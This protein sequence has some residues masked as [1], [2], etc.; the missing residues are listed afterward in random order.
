[1]KSTLKSIFILLTIINCSLINNVAA[2]ISINSDGAT[3]DASAM[4]DVSS[5]SKGILIPRMTTAERTTITS[6][7]TGLMVYDTDE[8]AFWYYN[9]TAWTAIG[10]SSAFTSENGITHSNSNSDDFVFGTGSLNHGSGTE[11]KMFFDKS[12]GAFRAGTV[13]GTNWDESNIGYYSTSM[14]YNTIASGSYATSFGFNTTASSNFS[15]SFGSSTTASGLFSTSFGSSTTASG[16]YATSFGESTTASGDFST[17]LGES[18]TASGHAATSLGSETL[19]SGDFSTSLGSVTIASGDNSTSLGLGT[20]AYSYGET[21]LG[22]YN[23]VYTPNDT[24]SFNSDDRLFVIGNGTAATKSDAMIVYKSGNTAINGDLTISGALVYD[25]AA[26]TSD[27]GITYSNNNDD[28]FLFGA[29]SLNYGSGTEYKM[30][31]D[32]SKG[33]FRAGTAIGT[34]WDESNVGIYSTSMGYN[35]IASGSYATS[36]GFNTTASGDFSTSFCSSTTASGNFSTSFGSSTTASGVFSTSFGESTTAS[37]AFSTSLG[38]ETTA[39]GHAATS[40]GSVTLASGNFSTSFGSATIASGD[41]ATSLGLGTTAYSY[42]ETALGLYNTVYTPNDTVSFNSDDRLFVIGNGTAATKSDAM[43]VYKSGN[44][45]INGDLTISGSLVYDAAAFTSDN[46]ITYSNNNNDDF[47]FGADSLNYGS[48]TEYKMFFDKS[49]GA[50]RAGTAIGTNWDE[51][52]IGSFSTSMGYNTTA[53]GSYATSFGFNTTA[54]GIFSTSFG[55]STTASGNFST[56]F[57]EATTAS[58]HYATSLGESTTASGHAATSLGESTT[59]SGHAA[60]SF[61]SVTLASG[62]FSTSLGSTTIASGDNATS[63]GLGTTAYSY[64]ETALGLYNTVY[65]PNDTVSFNSD[66]RLFVIGNGTAAT[67][68][69]AMIVYKSGNTAINGDLT[70]SGALVYDAAAFT[71]E[72]GITYSNNNDDNFVFGADSLNYGSGTET[73]MFF[74]KSKGAFRAGSVSAGYWDEDDLGTYSIGLGASTIASGYSSTSIGAYAKSTGDY[75]TSLGSYTTSSGDYSTSFGAY[76]T[77]S[78]DYATSFGTYTTASGDYAT[79]FGKSTEASGKYSTS[80]GRN[81][82]AYSY[83]ET[84]LGLYNTVYNADNTTDFDS[85]DR[86]FV[87]GNGTAAS[88]SDAMIVYKSGNT[89]INGDLT[90]SGSLI[91]DNAAAF[92]SDNGIT[93]AVSNSDDLVFGADSLDYSNSGSHDY[94]MFFDISLG[95]FRVGRVDNEN[96]DTDSMGISSFSAGNSSIASGNN[97]TALGGRT[98]AYGNNSFAVGGSSIAYGQ[99]STAIGKEIEAQSY[100]EFAIGTYNT[101]YTPN[102][103]TSQNAADRLFV[104]GNGTGSSNRSDAL[105]VYKNGNATLAGDLTANGVFHASDIR[106]KENINTSQYGLSDILK[107]QVRDYQFKKDDTRHLHTGFLA[108]QL[109]TVFPHAVKEGGDDENINPWRVDYASLTPLLV[110]GIQEQQKEIKQQQVEI[111]ELRMMLQQLQVQ[112][113]NS[114]IQSNK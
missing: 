3:P 19:A 28:D 12:K 21:A 4:L 44:T 39:S 77:A 41:N 25:A 10:G 52:N 54:S 45:T 27:N 50:F 74:N 68:S 14:G 112:N 81:T 30:F 95:A 8:S 60:T 48:G 99:L 1:M 20:T 102:G 109:H 65:T 26:F 98:A 73:K 17:S 40:L 13:S 33:A 92:T 91:Y 35:T 69:N 24:V 105:I 29:D 62:N 42:G 97:S 79:S 6:P 16:Y 110:K 94:K 100:G 56:S 101:I 63:L 5:A 22:L 80:F 72:N 104:I 83:G 53:S 106:L 108:Q 67:K 84:V 7:A 11:Y 37:G 82:T 70:I 87:I 64:G 36:F 47:L 93:S 75:T 66:D 43:I 9:G 23:T 32:K 96:W 61:G 88:K 57:G 38:E 114:T 85:D 51:S 103:V 34:N 31:F 111:N 78:G 107:I 46:G 59:A 49:K 2:Q 89:E 58:G 86:L 55:S 76:T 18:T 90:I 15:T 71:S 113:S